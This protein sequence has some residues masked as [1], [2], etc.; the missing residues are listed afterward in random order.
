MVA[1]LDKEISGCV[2]KHRAK[3]ACYEDMMQQ[4][5]IPYT[6]GERWILRKLTPTETERLMGFP[7]GYTSVPWLGKLKE[8]APDTPRYAALGNSMIVPIMEWLGR[9]IEAVNNQ[10][11][12]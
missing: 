4:S 12:Q 10:M 6:D 7:D 9:S 8:N 2:T 11:N 3:G 5:V 1:Q